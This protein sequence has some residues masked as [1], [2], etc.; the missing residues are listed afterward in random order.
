[1]QKK[2]TI[3]QKQVNRVGSGVVNRF[4]EKLLK[5]HLILEIGNLK[6]IIKVLLINSRAERTE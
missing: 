2:F 1:M 3:L 6:Y 4:F 5:I